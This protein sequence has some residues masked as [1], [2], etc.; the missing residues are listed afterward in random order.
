MN[1][2]RYTPSTWFDQV[3]NRMLEDWVPAPAGEVEGP[4][5]PTY[6]PR[7]DVR[8]EKD[9]VIL[10]AEMP[11]MEKD[12]LSVHVEEGVLTI[13]GQ[14][15]SEQTSEKDGLFL[16][17]RAYGAFKRQFVLPDSIDP[18]K[19]DAQYQAGVLKLRLAKKPE[20]APKQINIRVGE[21]EARKI[22]VN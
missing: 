20:A 11:G 2:V 17:E 16:S 4:V 21:S 5:V 7:V 10:T 12:D 15:K 19:I 14:K 1:L 18:E 3:F 13:T 6:S 8:N 9:A 22:G